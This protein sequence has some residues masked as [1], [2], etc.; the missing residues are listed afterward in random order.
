M[1]KWGRMLRFH[2]QAEGC[3]QELGKAARI[4]VLPAAFNPPTIAHQA[5]AARAA[6]EADRV[7]LLMPEQMPHKRFDGASYEQRIAMLSRLAEEGPYT[8]CSTS[9]GL[10]VDIA[11]ACHTA[12]PEAQIAI[13]CGRDAAERAMLWRYENSDTLSRLFDLAELWVFARQGQVATPT[14]WKNRIRHFD[15][16]EALQAVAATAIRERL[17]RGEDWK[18]WVPAAIHTMVAEIYAEFGDRNRD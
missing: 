4:V 12:Y 3:G 1:T 5:I 11:A 18:D 8:V 14:P 17:R 13:A 9:A 10:F 16:D 7:L 2:K 6:E 15:M